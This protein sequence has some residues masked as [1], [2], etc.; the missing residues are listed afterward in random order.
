MVKGSYAGAG[1]SASGKEIILILSFIAG[2]IIVFYIL[3]KKEVSNIGGGI[4][5]DLK[6]AGKSVVDT[7]N[8]GIN[9]ALGYIPDPAKLMPKAPLTEE[10]LIHWKG[11]INEP[12]LIDVYGV[13]AN[14]QPSDSLA[15][16]PETGSPFSDR[17]MQ[18]AIAANPSLVGGVQY[19]GSPVTQ[20]ET[21]EI[22]SRAVGY[23]T[24]KITW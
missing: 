3:I 23:K 2:L 15:Y 4:V 6:T 24:Y 12:L 8:N 10:Q 18:E 13:G 22:L 19:E 5:D 14:W 17:T 9:T 20:A 21:E 11:D 7:I 16:D 1:A